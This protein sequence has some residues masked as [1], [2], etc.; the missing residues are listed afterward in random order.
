MNKRAVIRIKGLVQR[1]GFRDRIQE[2]AYRLGITGWVRNL[3]DRSVTVVGEGDKE[4]LKEF[5]RRI[6]TL[7]PS[8]IITC[9]RARYKPATGEFTAFDVIRDEDPTSVADERA[10]AAIHLLDDA[11][12][13][14]KDVGANVR[15]VGANVRTVGA[16]V[17]AVGADVRTVGAD[18]KAMDG[19]MSGHFSRLD[20]KYGEF[21]KT[22]KGMAC[23]MK[24][25]AKDIKA[26]RKTASVASPP[27]RRSKMT[28]KTK[29]SVKARRAPALSA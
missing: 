23:D 24:G 14:I 26:I 29:T 7:V 4:Q 16:N 13:A 21:G 2:C 27:S 18:V 9:L 3:P 17:K 12:D 25:V 1:A 10:D 28:G 11:I 15:T 8:I 22:L 5:I 19:H 20:H 6:R